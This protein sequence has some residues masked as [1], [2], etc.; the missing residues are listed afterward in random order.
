MKRF[1]CIRVGVFAVTLGM[2]A[3]LS[4][5]AYAEKRIG[6]LL[7]SDEPR[8][9]ESRDGVIEQ[10][11]KEGFAEP[12]VSFVIENAGGNKGK[13]ADIASKWAGEKFDMIIAAGTSAAVAVAKEIKTTPV[14][15]TMTLQ[16]RGHSSGLRL[17][18]ER[19]ADWRGARL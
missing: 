17:T 9:L 13:A 11:K 10:M 1:L 12:K 8:Y 2:A 18:R 16:R 4:G 19:W 15:F 5:L 3:L 6:I 7:W 14:V